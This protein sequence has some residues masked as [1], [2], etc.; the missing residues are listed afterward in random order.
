MTLTG[1]SLPLLGLDFHWREA[2]SF[3]WLTI[4]EPNDLAH[5]GLRS[6]CPYPVRQAR[7]ET[8]EVLAHMLLTDEPRRNDPT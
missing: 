1:Q 7:G 6:E 8:I 2:A 5:P 4:V 3:A